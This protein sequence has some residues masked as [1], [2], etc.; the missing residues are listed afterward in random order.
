LR[1][2]YSAAPVNVELVLTP[3]FREDNLPSSSSFSFSDPF[4]DTVERTEEEPAATAENT[5]AAL[6][7]YRRVGNFDAS[8]YAY[9][10]FWRA[11]GTEV[12]D[13]A[14]PSVVTTFYPELSVY[15]ASAQGGA[16]GGVVSLEAGYYHSRQ[17]ESGEDSRIPNSRVIFLAGY[18]RQIGEEFQLGLQ[19]YG[20]IMEDYQS[21]RDSLPAGFS[22][23]KKYRDIVTLKLEKSYRYQ[24]LLISLFTFYSPAESDYL[25]RPRITYR[26]TDRFSSALG[27]NVF[28]GGGATVFG[29]LD[30][31]DNV[32][33][34]A[35]FDF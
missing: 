34:W 20:E 30:D 11:P 33:V 32:Y 21:Y 13:P 25:V 16:A 6:R 1:V 22:A 23:Q 5:E 27:A 8:V 29:R 7:L 28:G 14:S 24:T 18:Q 15:G 19:Y 12:D 31:D 3:F 10:G 26:F 9:R 2:R 4:A 35:R 17:D